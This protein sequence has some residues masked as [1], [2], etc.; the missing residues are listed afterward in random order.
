V[1]PSAESA[2]REEGSN[3]RARLRVLKSRPIRIEGA[4]ICQIRR[5]AE[6][7]NPGIRDYRLDRESIAK[8]AIVELD[9]GD[10]R[11]AAEQLRA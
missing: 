10:S 2:S 11:T 3:D 7:D 4:R 5:G 8:A 1:D 9:G 6:I